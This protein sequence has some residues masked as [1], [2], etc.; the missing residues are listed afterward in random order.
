MRETTIL[1]LVRKQLQRRL[2][3]LPMVKRG[4]QRSR[5]VVQRCAA[6]LARSIEVAVLGLGWMVLPIWP[7]VA[8]AIARDS[9]YVRR[10]PHTLGAVVRHIRSTWRAHAIERFLMRRFGPE[11]PAQSGAIAGECTHCGNCC[12]YRNCVFLSLDAHGQSSCRIY[13]GRVWEA[14]A[15]GDYPVDR[16][17]IALYRCPS[18]TVVPAPISGDANVIPIFPVTV[19]GSTTV[20]APDKR[21]AGRRRSGVDGA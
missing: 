4:T 8:A 13:G 1:P 7:V 11:I 21:H 14:L 5:A 2:R 18:F 10:F 3:Q 6:F 9:S 19:P 20:A 15:C 12:L 17:D 16:P